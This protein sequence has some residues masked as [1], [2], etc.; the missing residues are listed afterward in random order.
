MLYRKH[1]YKAHFLPKRRQS[2]LGVEL[3]TNSIFFQTTA[4]FR[5]LEE[6]TSNKTRDKR[7][8]VR[9]TMMRNFDEENNRMQI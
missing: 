7:I 9:E 8:D 6:V 3:F 4:I 1:I 5:D 2:Y